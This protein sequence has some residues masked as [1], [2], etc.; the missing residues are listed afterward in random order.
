[1]RLVRSLALFY[2]II[3]GLTGPGHAQSTATVAPALLGNLQWRSI[4]PANTGGRIDDFAVARVPGQPDA[5]YVATASGGVFKSTNQ[6]TSWAPIFDR[7]DAMMSIGDIAVAPSNPNVVWVGTGEANNRQSS[8]WG[9]GVYRSIDAG[10]SW[11]SAGLADTR[12]IGRIVID[13]SN[14]DIV[15]VAAA[16]HLWGSNSE[17]GVFKT[18]DGGRT[19][20]KVLYVDDNTGATDLVMDPQD[21]QTLFAAMYQRQRK[22]WGFNGGGPGSGIFR[23]R[24]GGATW[25]RLSNGLPQGDKGRIGLDIFHADPRVIFAV[26]EASGRES[27]VYRSADRG[28]TWQEWSTLNPRPMYF[29]QIRADPRDAARVY[30]LGSN[31]GFYVSSDGGK[32]FADALSGVHSED[33]ALWI[34]PDDTNHLIVGGDGGVSIS[35]DRGQTW[36]FRDNL[37]VG[38]FYEISADMQDPYVICGGLQDNGHWCVPSAT[39]NR[40]GISNRD[41]FNIGSG[42]GFYARLDPTDART[43]IIESQDGRAN[44]VNLSTLERQ[45]ISP[46]FGTDVPPGSRGSLSPAQPQRWNWN[47]PIVMSSFDPKVLY[48]GSSMVFKS[49]DRGASWKAISAD[50]TAGV[51]RE[52]LQM[53]GA[54][55]PER[56]L[57]RHDGVTSFPTLTTIGES[58]LDPKLLY[59]GSDDGRLTM[60]RDGGQNWTNLNERIPGLPPGTYVSSVLPSRYLSGRVYATFDGHYNDDYRPY[61]YV[62]DDYGRTWRSIAAGLPAASVHRLREH[63]RNGR[64]L[65]VGHERGIHFSIDGGAS[66]SS[67]TLNMP[68][69]PVDDILIHPRDNDLIVGTHGRSIWVLDNI[70]SLEALTPE[71]MQTD[72]FLVP[73]ARARLLAVYNPQAWYGAGQY[74]SPNPELGASFDYY[75]RVASKNDVSVTIVDARGAPVRTIKGSSRSG[76]NRASWDLRM[77]PPMPDGAREATAVGGFGGAAQGPLVLPGVYSVTVNAAGRLLKGELRVEGDPRVTFSD[78]DR[79]ARQTALLNLYALLKSLAAARAA[80]ATAAGQLDVPGGRG[81]VSSRPDTASRLTRVQSDLVA[82]F[83]TVNSLS[84]AIEGYSGLPTADQRRQ[85]D[86]AFDD[87][88]RAIDA[89]NRVLQTDTAPS[90]LTVPQKLTKEQ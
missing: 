45:A 71:A 38:Q 78:A 26:V 7:V 81:I 68:T 47:T 73:P 88:A 77:E 10:H 46:L 87:A 35:W 74:F 64:L 30:L 89:L 70:S 52:S 28:D 60:T 13:P 90:R 16:G 23:S 4:G 53:M 17:R 15:Y 21:P 34:D 54:A 50:L 82:Q 39:R 36:L 44:R 86:S 85:L 42:D 72:A 75:L 55:V 19:W 32:T 18:S 14:P 69:V 51:D 80:G 76:L 41:G 12:H 49:P 62:S 2:F 65:F 84:R 57:S 37:P 11:T 31:R 27:G 79:R 63:P 67:L 24:D 1:M 5:I 33:H 58:P 29:S 25:T 66:W 61:A 40:N 59:A 22:A 6:G 56:A 8:S 43:A 83:N 48:M 3:L 9:D 20:A